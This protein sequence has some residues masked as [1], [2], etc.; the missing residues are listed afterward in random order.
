LGVLDGVVEGLVGPALCAPA[1]GAAVTATNIA[2]AEVT[3]GSDRCLRVFTRAIIDNYCG[4][5]V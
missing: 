3:L 1:K 4:A 5:P 2:I